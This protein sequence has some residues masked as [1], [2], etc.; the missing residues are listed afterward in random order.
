MPT[1]SA[2]LLLYRSAAGRVEV[3]LMH[4]DARTGPSGMTGH[5]LPQRGVRWY[6]DIES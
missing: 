5:G 6:L 1:R 4:P 3:L 2:G